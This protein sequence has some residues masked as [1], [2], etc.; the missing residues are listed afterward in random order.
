MWIVVVAGHISSTSEN[1]VED[2]DLPLNK[3]TMIEL[4]LSKNETRGVFTWFSIIR[5]Y[6]YLLYYKI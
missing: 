6:I 5:F 1:I 4:S 3:K 2:T